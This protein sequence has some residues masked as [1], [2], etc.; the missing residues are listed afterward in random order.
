MKLKELRGGGIQNTESLN[1]NIIFKV[2]KKWNT[3][4]EDEN[5]PRKKKISRQ[6]FEGAERVMLVIPH[7]RNVPTASPTDIQQLWR[8]NRIQLS[9]NN[10][11]LP[12]R[13][14]SLLLFL[15]APAKNTISTQRTGS[16]GKAS[17]STM[18]LTLSCKETWFPQAWKSF[19]NVTYI[20][21]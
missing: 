19:L 2:K 5:L 10:C 4:I 14:P 13:K 3:H 11:P 18:S 9:S 21:V 17:P 16:H 8:T 20:Q 6:S 12:D 7:S 15:R 1:I